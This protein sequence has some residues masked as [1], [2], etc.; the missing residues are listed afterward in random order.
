ME[1]ITSWTDRSKFLN[2]CWTEPASIP[3]YRLKMIQ[4][5]I[6]ELDKDKE[7]T[8]MD[9]GCGTGL[10]FSYLPDEYKDRYYGVDFT[11]E[12]I[13]H[14]KKEYPNNAHRFRRMDLT[15]LDNNEDGYFTGHSIY[16]TQNVMQHILLFQ[17]ALYNMFYSCDGVI[18]ICE[19]T[20]ALNT[21]IVGYEPAYRWRFNLKDFYDILTFYARYYGYHGDVEILGQPTSTAKR[22][23]ALTIFRVYRHIP[24]ILSHEILDKYNEDYFTRDR[25]VIRKWKPRLS[26]KQ[27][28][29]NSIKK[30]IKKYRSLL[31]F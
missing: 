7:N 3:E 21:C 1:G 19:R 17:E 30:K 12:M 13:D 29:I 15:I 8:L 27:K 24:V 5:I 25:T 28:I 4:A 18:L 23:K 11:Q 26:K 9:C 16:V 14:C 6:E 2:D 22:E 31:L 20:H 10:L